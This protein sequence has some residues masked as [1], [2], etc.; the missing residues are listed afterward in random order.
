ME[1]ET[2]KVP[3][4]EEEKTKRIQEIQEEVRGLQKKIA[5]TKE[6]IEAAKREERERRYASGEWD[7]IEVPKQAGLGEVAPG[8]R[9]TLRAMGEDITEIESWYRY[10]QDIFDVETVTQTTMYGAWKR[11]RNSDKFDMRF[12]EDVARTKKREYVLDSADLT[13]G[14][15]PDVCK[16][17]AKHQK[18]AMDKLRKDAN[19]RLKKQGEKEFFATW[20][21]P[22]KWKDDD[23]ESYGKD[24][25]KSISQRY[26]DLIETHRTKF[27]DPKDEP[28]YDTVDK[29]EAYNIRFKAGLKMY[30]QVSQNLADDEFTGMSGMFRNFWVVMRN[31]DVNQLQFYSKRDL[32]VKIPMV[33]FFIREFKNDVLGK[34]DMTKKNANIFSWLV[35][36]AGGSFIP[37]NEISPELQDWYEIIKAI[38]GRTDARSHPS[39]YGRLREYGGSGPGAAEAKGKDPMEAPVM[40]KINK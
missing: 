18:E 30:D 22:G 27:A 31:L 20:D 3:T 8:L 4:Q 25:D 19:E 9:K 11:V 12:K 33:E 34:R 26:Q 15:N 16:E 17:I 28:I 29:N 39:I 32:D 6:E 37:F 5:K 21:W 23:G 38:V 7:R 24:S 2:I 1:N 10:A 36:M 13:W 40:K 14:F 35:N